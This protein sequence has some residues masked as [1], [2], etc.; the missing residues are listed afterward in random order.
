MEKEPSFF[1]V[2][3]LEVSVFADCPNANVATAI[4]SNVDIIRLI[5]LACNYPAGDRF[6][7]PPLKDAFNNFIILPF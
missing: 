1:E 4:N 2:S 6:T 3:F 5:I 7:T